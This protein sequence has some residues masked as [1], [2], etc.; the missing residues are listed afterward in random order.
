MAEAVAVI[1]AT[2]DLVSTDSTMCTQCERDCDIKQTALE[3]SRR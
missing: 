1:T 2:A 3:S